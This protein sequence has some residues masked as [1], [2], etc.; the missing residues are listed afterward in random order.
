[1]KFLPFLPFKPMS[2]MKKAHLFILIFVILSF[3][4]C[5]KSVTNFTSLQVSPIT[6]TLVISSDQYEIIGEVSGT[7]LG[8]TYDLAKDAALGAAINAAPQ[9]DALILPKFETEVT[10]QYNLFSVTKSYKVTCKAKAVK[11][12]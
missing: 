2:K 7:G 10:T 3:T 8:G 5:S 1:M 9:A 6:P 11:L 12:K 4:S